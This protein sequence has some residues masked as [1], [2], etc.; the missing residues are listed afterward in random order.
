MV[1]D[2]RLINLTTSRYKIIAKILSLRLKKVLAITIVETQ[3]A[4][5]KG[6]Q[7]LDCCPIANELV[8]KLMSGELKKKGS[9]KSISRRLTTMWIRVFDF[10]LLK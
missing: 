9:L 2:F 10:L 6:R 4:F 1:R 7:I 3:C 8:E 5:I